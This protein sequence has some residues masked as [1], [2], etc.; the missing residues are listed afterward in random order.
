MDSNK[1]I[2][3]AQ[4]K[5]LLANNQE[6]SRNINDAIVSERALREIYL[7]GFEIIVKKSQPWTIMTSYNKINGTYIPIT[8]TAKIL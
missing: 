1:V 5:L 7:K 4:K 3:Q 8:N 6:T 2:F